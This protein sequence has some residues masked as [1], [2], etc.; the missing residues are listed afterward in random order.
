MFM[1]LF[2]VAA[3][4][5]KRCQIL[6]VDGEEAIKTVTKGFPH[7]G[8]WRIQFVCAKFIGEENIFGLPPA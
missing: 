5:G 2:V 7:S 6:A 3:E 8:A 4:N 1:Q